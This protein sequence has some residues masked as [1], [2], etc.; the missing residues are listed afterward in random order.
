MHPS[1]S[2]MLTLCSTDADPYLL[3]LLDELVGVE[4]T[5]GAGGSGERGREPQGG[6]QRAQL[7]PR[8]HQVLEQGAVHSSAQQ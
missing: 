4:P 2:A 1:N 3:P 5:R 8:D 7:L 6:R